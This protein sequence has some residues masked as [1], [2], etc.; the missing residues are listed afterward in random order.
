MREPTYLMI[1]ALA[2][3][4]V[5]PPF[6]AFA[7]QDDLPP[8]EPPRLE[9]SPIEAPP[10]ETDHPGGEVANDATSTPLPQ[11]HF[12]YHPGDLEGVPYDTMEDCTE[13]RRL[14]GNVGVCVMK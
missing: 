10:I 9:G 7:Q 13:A 1:V 5:A 11:K 14:A 2:S 12:Y 8:I 6:S 3:M 4:L